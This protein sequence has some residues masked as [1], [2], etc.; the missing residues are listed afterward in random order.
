MR[1]FPAFSIATRNLPKDMMQ[2]LPRKFFLRLNPWL[3][4]NLK[5]KKG[6]KKPI[7]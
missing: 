2:R 4:A 3:N 5:R 6:N 7:E 1:P